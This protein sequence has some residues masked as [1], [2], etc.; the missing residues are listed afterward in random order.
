VSG[1]PPSVSE[2]ALALEALSKSTAATA[3]P[4]T[5]F[6]ARF[7]NI[8]RISTPYSL[9][10]IEGSLLL[11][12]PREEKRDAKIEEKFNQVVNLRSH[13]IILTGW[14]CG[15]K[16]STNSMTYGKACRRFGTQT[17]PRG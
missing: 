10:Q 13:S 15:E 9:F 3:S 6:F 11:K 16:H 8:E 12:W 5:Q 7:T 4:A 1:A 2:I 17:P 14:L